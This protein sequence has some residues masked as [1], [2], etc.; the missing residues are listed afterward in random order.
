MM[1]QKQAEMQAALEKA[2]DAAESWFQLSDQQ[3][4]E[5]RAT[6]NRRDP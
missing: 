4:K 6:W 3:R 1:H 2:R 5:V